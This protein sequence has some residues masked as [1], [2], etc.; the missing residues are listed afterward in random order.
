MVSFSSGPIPKSEIRTIIIDMFYCY[1]GILI[2]IE[3]GQSLR[4]ATLYFSL[5]IYKA[6]AV[7]WKIAAIFEGY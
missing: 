1:L 4:W 2:R 6:Y 5:A 7:L 3:L